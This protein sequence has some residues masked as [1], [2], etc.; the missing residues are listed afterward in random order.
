MPCP[1]WGAE[2]DS[3]VAILRY[4]CYVGCKDLLSLVLFY[5]DVFSLVLLGSDLLLRW[6]DYCYGELVLFSLALVV[7]QSQ[8]EFVFCTYERAQLA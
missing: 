4:L 3:N 2:L 6:F 8:D 5:N 7:F 1:H